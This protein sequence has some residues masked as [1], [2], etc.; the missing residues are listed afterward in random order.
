MANNQDWCLHCGLGEPE[1]L[2]ARP[3]WQSLA[4][5]L[6]VALVLAV[7]AAAAAYAALSEKSHIPARK[8][9]VASTPGVLGT[10]TTA[11]T[12]TV[13]TI[14]STP[15]T[16]STPTIPPESSTPPKIPL[17]TPTP[18]TTNTPETTS[19]PTQEESGKKTTSGET[20]TTPASA[21][22]VQP[23]VLDNNAA[24]TY[25][26]YGY[27]QSGFGEPALAT[28]GDPATAWTAAVQPD[29]APNMAEGLLIDLKSPQH[30][31]KLELITPSKGMTVEIYGAHLAQPPASIT[32]KGW[33]ALASSRVIKKHKAQIKLRE[34]AKTFRLVLLWLT[35]APPGSTREA[36]GQVEVQEIALFPPS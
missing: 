36:P 22:E 16:T 2:G 5:V 18:E 23:I 32:A 35:K 29:S 27:A 28:D 24:S 6:A 11:P 4:G 8:T 26:P 19:T 17:S 14:P 7:G 21:N 25:N 13:P 10:A 15:E 31:G 3:S 33:V 34:S 1:A 20:K 9:T 12:S 30:V